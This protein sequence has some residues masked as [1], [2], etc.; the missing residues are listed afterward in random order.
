MLVHGKADYISLKSIFGFLRGG[1]LWA[2]ATDSLL[3]IDSEGDR[4]C[5]GHLERRDA[6]FKRLQRPIPSA[7]FVFEVV[8]S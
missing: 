7:S 2:R 1:F 5:S 4:L 3:N 6:H 8:H